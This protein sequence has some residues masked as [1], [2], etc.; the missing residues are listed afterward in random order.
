MFTALSRLNR[1]LLGKPLPT[2][3]YHH[4]RLSNIAALAILASDALSSVAYAT[5]EILFVLVAAGSGALGYSLPISAG[6]ILL[7]FVITISYRQTIRAY[8]QGGS[9]YLVSRENLGLHAGLVAAA[10]LLIDY[11]LTV[12]VSISAGIAAI[13]SAIPSL[14]PYR[15]ELCLVAIFLIMLANLR[16]V[17]EAGQIFM[18]PTYS[19]IV[20]IFLLIGVGLFKQATGQV[21]S[22]L[23]T[24]PQTEPLSLFLI[25]RAFAAG[26]TALTGVEAISDGVLVFKPPEWKNA[27]I[28]L[29]WMGGIL[30]LMFLGITYLMQ[31]YHIIP[32]EGQTAVSV[33]A[34]EIV[35]GGFLYYWL[36]ISTLFILLLA[37]NTSYADFPRLSYLVARDGFLPRQLSFLGDR[38]VYANGIRLLSLCAAIL[39][40]L[41]K[42]D[43]NSLIPLYA[44][45]VF[46]SFT[47]SQLGM[48]LHWFKEKSA[49][50]WQSALINGLGALTT[51]IVLG[52]IVAT[53]FALGAWL[54][55]VA[56]PLLVILFLAIHRHYE[57]IAQ[58]FRS[59][60]FSLYRC[61]LPAP[62]TPIKHSAIVLVGQ[63]NRG[64]LE[65][66]DYA[67]LIAQEIV[68]IH[69]DIGTTNHHALRKRWEELEIHVPLNILDSPYRSIVQPITDFVTEFEAQRPDSFS[70]IVIPVIVTRYWWEELLHNQTALF[71]R[72]GLRT[73]QCRIVTTVRYYI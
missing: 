20:S 38:L 42:G 4:E 59:E 53:K 41:F 72:R 12:T 64:T 26:C 15:I 66:L 30:G 8:P 33:L 18:V 24:I 47:L 43:V 35:G 32:E 1:F 13:T 57:S 5:E 46:T 70:T 67:R 56:I 49:R 29:L 19:F 45:G 7:L 17:R 2:S 61:P 73:N 9:A 27:R 40:V 10:S 34:R 31:V 65:A 44:V 39:I 16:G 22:S 51:A 36:Q 50:W 71:I 54:V 55:V 21:V 69:V 62:T 3:A 23:P 37:A 52:V 25:L 68:A 48:V 60:E 28:T 14:T 58:H 6:I 11:I 63:L